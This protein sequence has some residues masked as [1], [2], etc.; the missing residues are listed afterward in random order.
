MATLID[1]RP[2]APKPAEPEASEPHDIAVNGVVISRQAIVEEARNHP[3]PNL[4]EA[5]AAS[6]R[7]L[8]IRELLLW[9]ARRIG[10]RAKPHADGKG[11]RETDDDALIRALIDSQVTV[12]E[13]DEETC[14]RYFE[15]NRQR[16]VTP[17]LYEVCHILVQAAEDDSEAYACAREKAE[18]L[19][20]IVVG[21]PESFADVARMH[22]DCPSADKGGRL[23]QVGPG[24]TTPEFEAALKK[25]K[26]SEI[27]AEPVATRYGFHIIRL[28]RHAPG[29]LLE[30][31]AAREEVARYLHAASWQR[32]VTQYIQIVAGR[33]EIEGFD[34]GAA[35]S[36]LVQ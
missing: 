14:R 12:P 23:G 20:D 32:A 19:A 15:N 16:F 33:A 8:V 26:E 27:T 35:A 2:K 18:R 1:K 17:D 36:P 34:I 7:A 28:D 24:E 3:A 9:E 10:L 29:R 21:E 31:E 6:A 4:A 13:A 11:R 5:L 22:S 25:L 30:F